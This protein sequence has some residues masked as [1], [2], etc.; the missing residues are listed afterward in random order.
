M[1]RTPADD[2]LLNQALSDYQNQQFDAAQQRIETYLA[3]ENRRPDAWTLGGMIRKAQRDLDGA[4]QAYR[5]AMACDPSYVDAY[6]NL[7]NLERGEGLPENAL[8]RYEQAFKLSPTATAANNVGCVLADLGRHGEAL[9]WHE[10]ALQLDP[11]A[12]DPRWDRALALLAQG[13]YL[14]GF[15]AY[16]SR[17]ERRLPIPREFSQPA[18]QGE[19]LAGKTILL[20][21][22]QGYGD[23]LQFLR[24]VPWV[25]ARG[26]RIVLEILPPLA[27]LARSLPEVEEVIPAG[28]PLPDFDVHASIMSL[29]HLLQLTLDSVPGHPYLRASDP[30]AAR[31]RLLALAPDAQFRIGIV[32]AGNPGVKNDRFRSPRLDV[33]RP[34]WS[35]PGV[36][37]FGLQKGDGKRDIQPDDPIIDLDPEIADFADTAN[38]I[39]ALDLVI[40]TDTSVAHLAG[41]LGTRFWVTLMQVAD[42]RWIGHPTRSLWYP[43][44]RLFRQPARGDWASVSQALR[45]ELQALVEHQSQPNTTIMAAL[46]AYQGGQDEPAGRLIERALDLAPQRPDVWTL[47]GMICRRQGQPR[48]AVNA[49]REALRRKPDFHDAACN[50]GNLLKADGQLAAAAATYRQLL[51]Q[52][53]GHL[54]ALRELS[55]VERLLGDGEGAVDT[56]RRALA[57][58]PDDAAAMNNLAAALSELG[59]HDEAR[60]MLADLLGK[61]PTHLEAQ[62]NLGVLLHKQGRD[63]EA[64]AQFEAVIARDPRHTRAQYNLAVVLQGLGDFKAAEAA[65]QRAIALNPGYFSALFNLGALYS[66]TGRFN[67]A[68]ACE[69]RCL[70]LNPS[71]LG[72]RA[73]ALHLAMKFCNWANVASEAGRLVQSIGEQGAM[74]AELPPFVLLSLPTEISEKQQLTA[75]RLSARNLSAGITPLPPVAIGPRPRLRIG[76]ASSDFHDHATMHLMRGLFAAHDRSQFSIHAYSWGPDDGSAYRQEAQQRIEHFVDLRGQGAE[77]IARRIRDDEIDLLVDLKG[78]TRDCKSEIFA[79]RPAPLQVQYLGYPGSM[80]AD[81]IDWI[82]TDR[83]VTPPHTQADYSERFAYLPHS[84]QVNDREQAIAEPR[85]DRAACGLPADTVVFTCFCT[86]YKIDPLIWGAWMNILHAVPNSVLW[87]CGGQAQ[88][89]ANLRAAAKARDIAV[90]RIIFGKLLPKAQHLSRLR[91]ADLFL[92][93]Y[94]YN[95]HTTASDALWAGVPVLTLPGRRFASRVGASLVNAVGMPEMIAADLADYEAKA[96]HLGNNPQARQACQ[97]KLVAN[98]LSTPLF[99]TAGFTRDLE[100]LY[101]TLW[102]DA[103]AG[104]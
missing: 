20:Y 103:L 51:A 84:Y 57:I 41:A 68:L 44:A 32:W 16:E 19:D 60:Q 87:L 34:L 85:P 98:R 61:H 27:R 47:Y 89:E 74:E 33:L 86:H 81:F 36:A 65:Y 13:D 54:A 42:W 45:T 94:W 99:D 14:A 62:Y 37:F 63:D 88:T 58:A 2:A 95:G 38:F 77:A 69:Q 24:F 76:Y 72:A 71:H 1:D 43:N 55:D 7:A 12:L 48:C 11:A 64:I 56:A 15:A 82:I 25:K 59:R 21:G 53:P 75:A 4:R 93:T 73:E 26:G 3:Q 90:D 23:A 30:A 22:E 8:P 46:D 79:Y 10:K 6:S 104:A 100:T 18:W 49:Y 29:P 96:I 80:G 40:T 97:Q 67:E 52:A 91:H 101:Q 28:S 92:D 35:V 5:Q 39:A 31:A 17:F 9:E 78:Y 83:I 70:A 66:F 50:L 102:Q